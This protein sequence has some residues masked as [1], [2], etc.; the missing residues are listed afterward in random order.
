MSSIEKMSE[1]ERLFP[2]KGHSQYDID[3]RA[4]RREGYLAALKWIKNTYHLDE[5]LLVLIEQEIAA[6]EQEKK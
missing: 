3:V 5:E 2:I 6:A 1:F 4:F